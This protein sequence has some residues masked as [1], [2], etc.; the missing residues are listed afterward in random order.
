MPRVTESCPVT[1]DVT[2]DSCSSDDRGGFSVG[3]VVKGFLF[4]CPADIP[5]LLNTLPVRLTAALKAQ[6]AT[7]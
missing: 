7:V 1:A 6:C 5:E 4:L 3:A 2:D